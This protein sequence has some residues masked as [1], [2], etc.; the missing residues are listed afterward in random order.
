MNIYFTDQN[1]KPIY[2]MGSVITLTFEKKT[3]LT[4]VL[5]KACYTL[6]HYLSTLY[7]LDMH[8]VCSLYVLSMYFVCTLY[9][10]CLYF[11]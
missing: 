9:V 4:N 2:L 8:F 6:V 3:S 5:T 7:L 10:L 1:N 11:V